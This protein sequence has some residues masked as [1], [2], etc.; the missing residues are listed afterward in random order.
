[1]SD[2]P[3]PG[4]RGFIKGVVAG[5]AMPGIPG[6]AAAQTQHA[7]AAESAERIQYPRTYTGRQLAMI[8]F[9]LGGIGTGSI[10][11]GGRGQLRDWEIFNRPDKG[12]FAQ[13]RV[14]IHL[15]A[16]GNAQTRRAGSG[17]AAHAALRGIF[18][19]SART[20]CRDCRGSQAPHS[21][22]NFRWRTSRFMIA[23]LPVKVSLE[24]F[25]PVH[26]SGRRR[27][28]TARGGAA[29]PRD[30]PGRRRGEGFDRLLHRQPRGRRAER[31]TRR[32][33]SARPIATAPSAG[34]VHDAIRFCPATDPLQGSFALCV[35]AAG[36]RP[37]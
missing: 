22:A 29:L 16:G 8:A 9:P 6:I 25:T 7:A 5:V 23:K 18:A 35:L 28:R 31:R 30:N 20:M 11:L 2:N 13:L 15:G 34:F 14:P 12:Q 24:A 17:S 10:S 27:I 1:M 32:T 37:A 19:D 33:N 21:R 4:R 26:P 36:Q 3:G